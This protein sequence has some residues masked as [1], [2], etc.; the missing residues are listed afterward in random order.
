LLKV[1][2]L[3]S[4]LSAFASVLGATVLVTGTPNLS[5]GMSGTAT[6][7]SPT[8]G[9]LINFDDLT[10]NSLLSPGAYSSSGVTSISAINSTVALS[11]EPF[12]GQTQ[13]NYIGPADFSNIDILISLTQSTDEIGIGLLAGSSNSFTLTARNAANTILGTYVVNVP[14]NG[15]GA[16][17]GYYAIQDSGLTIKSLEISG[18]G[19]ID[20]LQFD[21]SAAGGVPEPADFALL[22][23][24]LTLLTALSKY[25]RK[26]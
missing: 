12:S 3:G 11:A 4:A 1:F 10:P 19:G 20:D 7:L 9:T 13:P 25:R 21:R 8:F 26:S 17:N 15:V 18:N 6:G 16:F 2:I 23:G 22:G 5:G 14:S 24:G